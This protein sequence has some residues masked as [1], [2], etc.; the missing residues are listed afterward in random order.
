MACKGLGIA[1]KEQL[2]GKP[3]VQNILTWLC[4]LTLIVC[5]TVQMNYLNK[6]LDMFNTSV[7]TPIYYVF[8]TTSVILASCILFQEWMRMSSKDV[9]GTLAGFG[10][11][12]SG[13]FL[14]HAFKDI[15]INWADLPST[16]TRST[17][18]ASSGLTDIGD[19]V[20][21]NGGVR[22]SSSGLT[23]LE[24]IIRSNGGSNGGGNHHHRDEE[25][26]QLINDIEIGRLRE[27]HK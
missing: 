18:G 13:I 15:N 9:L 8:F 26:V 1:I 6:A 22:G 16:R 19:I 11:I 4:V 17:N 5:I 25:E 7:V 21:S 10:T 27:N 3:A 20:R 14:L 12:V 24:D 23:D 2:E